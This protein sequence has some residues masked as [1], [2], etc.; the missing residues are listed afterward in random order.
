[1]TSRTSWRAS[2]T[3]STAAI[4]SSPPRAAPEALEILEPR[5]R[6]RHPLRSADAGH[7]RRPVPAAAPASSSPTPSACS[8]PATPRSRPSSTPSIR[9]ASSATST[10]RGTPSSWRRSSR[11]AAEQYELLAERKR[12]IVRA[13]GGQRP[14]R[15]GQPRPGRGRPAQDGVPRGRQPRVQHADHDRPGAERA[16]A[17]GEP[18]PRAAG[19][20]D[21][22]ADLPNRPANSPGSSRRCSS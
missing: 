14:A 8:S 16:A 7:D 5:G 11:Q 21:R 2:A 12:L 22:R 13:A 1:M 3:S 9:A 17:A 4:T 10:S 15:R 20:G 6:P 19:A 18:R